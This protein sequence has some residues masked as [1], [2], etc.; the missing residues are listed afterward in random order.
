MTNDEAK[1]LK[2]GDNIRIYQLDISVND[3]IEQYGD[4]FIRT[5]YG[6]FNAS[7]CEKVE[8]AAPEGKQE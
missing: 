8:A 7:V 2:A 6:D 5:D 3:V 4:V 1:A